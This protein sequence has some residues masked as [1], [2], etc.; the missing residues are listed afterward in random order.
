MPALCA[1]KLEIYISDLH[2]ASYNRRNLMVSGSIL[3]SGG[4]FL[5]FTTASRPLLGPTQPPVEWIPGVKRLGHEADHSHPVPTS[6]M[7]RAM[8][9]LPHTYSWRGAL[10]RGTLPIPVRIMGHSFQ[11]FIQ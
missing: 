7:R 10:S 4:D 11:C 6:V 5:L 1:M 3:C 2:D 8:P 9:P